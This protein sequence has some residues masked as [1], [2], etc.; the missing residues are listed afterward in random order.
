MLFF[1][2]PSVPKAPEAGGESVY[3]YGY[4]NEANDFVQ[5]EKNIVIGKD[6][7]AVRIADFEDLQLITKVNYIPDKFVTPGALEYDY[8]IVDL[9]K[10]FEFAEKG[11]LMFVVLNLDP[12]DQDFYEQQERLG[13]YKMGDYWKFSFRL[14]KI[15]SA[16]NVYIRSDLIDRHGEIENY[17]FIDFTS[18]YNEK[19]TK[20]T[21]RTESTDIPLTF[22]TRREALN[23]TL[24]SAKMITVHY[25]SDG[26]IYSGIKDAPFIGVEKEIDKITGN[27]QSLLIA[28]AVIALVIF[29]VFAVLSLLKRTAEFIPA[30][31]YIFGIAALLF[32]RFILSGATNTPLFW[33]VVALSSPFA[34][35]LGALVSMSPRADK[36][37]VKYVLGILPAVGALFACILP[38]VPFNAAQG[39]QTA[40][41]I[42]RAV[43]AVALLVF[44]GLNVARKQYDNVLSCVCATVVAVAFI[45]GLFLPQISPAYLNP[46]FW[47]CAITVV[48]TFV[49]VFFV[50]RDT[51]RTNVYLTANMQMEIDR[52][53][54]DI[55]AIITERD[56]LLQFV[57]H[58]M[59]KPLMSSLSLLDIAIERENDAE[60]IKTLGIIKQNDSRVVTNL[61]EIG[62]FAKFNYIAEP[63][64]TEDL[65]SL[66]GLSYKYHELDCNANGIILVNS[67]GKSY[68]VFVK[69]QGL[70]NVVSNIIMNAVEHAN[71]KT[72]TI[73]VK[74]EKNRTVLCIADDGKG[75]AS[76]LDVFKAY[77]T[78]NSVESHGKTAGVGL[79]ICK[80]II[81][82]MNGSLTYESDEHGTVF[83]I[84][85][86]T[87]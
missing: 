72:I 83:Y 73:S 27:S 42:I 13:K 28:F 48:A 45:A 22:Y 82:S 29:S 47:L 78:E 23:N 18:Y 19:T 79:Y 2:A 16:S 26:G 65:Y 17:D 6:I 54:K 67:V 50:M 32:S 74:T 43:C 31:I 58:D 49:N 7:T 87:A 52:Q 10:P 60:Q 4:K 14:P 68:P 1:Y 41:L 53:I 75:I 39:L 44:I 71:C 25:Q 80:N 34:V 36:R 8:Q 3:R 69:R 15:F 21:S 63:S 38:F 5:E 37:Y 56:N 66:C 9:T 11:T 33:A 77:V 64:Q 70:E 81:E 61:S 62:S 85:L 84:S 35:M 12:F 76:D 24:S 51:E 86:L 59:K 30:L 55:K 57:S 40:C 46:I 20:F